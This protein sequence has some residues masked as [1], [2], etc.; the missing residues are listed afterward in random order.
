MSVLCNLN[1]D[2]KTKAVLYSIY[3]LVEHHNV[4]VMHLW[5]WIKTNEAKVVQERVDQNRSA[6]NF[7]GITL[8]TSGSELSFTNWY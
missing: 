3:P 1:C 4:H 2:T 7:W 5:E 8:K 6:C